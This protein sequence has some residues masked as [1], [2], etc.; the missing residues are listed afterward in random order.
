MNQLDIVNGYLALLTTQDVDQLHKMLTEDATF[1]GPFF[2][3]SGREE[4]VAGMQRWMQVPKVIH[5]EQQFAA[6][7][8]MCSLFTIDLTAPAGNKVRVAMADWITVRNGKVAKERVYFDPR[9]WAKAI[10]K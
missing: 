3:A 6:G 10:G 9:E 7:D 2:N 8:E 1:A 5:M 4:F